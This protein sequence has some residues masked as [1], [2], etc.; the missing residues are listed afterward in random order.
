MPNRASRRNATLSAPLRAP[1]ALRSKPSDELA[2]RDLDTHQVGLYPGEAQVLDLDGGQHIEASITKD[3][4]E[5]LGLAVG[6]RV[7]AV[8]KATEV[9]I[10]VD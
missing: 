7:T 3:A 9:M 8:V 1:P 6:T 4:A 10:G 2:G 5:E